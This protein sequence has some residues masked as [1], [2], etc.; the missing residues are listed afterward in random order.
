MDPVHDFALSPGE[1]VAAIGAGGTTRLLGRIA[2]DWAAA[3][4][5]PWIAA[6]TR[7]DDRELPESARVL[8]L[9]AEPAARLAAVREHPLRGRLGEA[10]AVG[11][12]PGATG[13]L[14]TLAEAEIAALAAEWG[15]DLVLVKADGTRGQPLKAHASHEPAIPA[16]AD[17]VIAVAGL[18]VLG[19]PLDEEHV[20]HAELAAELWGYAPGETVDESLVVRML[21]EPEG[22][23]RRVPPRARYAAFLHTR[24][25]ARLAAA[26]GRIAESLARAGVACSSGDLGEPAPRR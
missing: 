3:G 17:L 11:V 14:G 13:P 20:H 21:A 15:A 24:G 4:G 23:R 18:W 8:R 5:R 9:P 19:E 6:T 2:L 26:A 10:L 25:D 7:L 16:R 1:W 22:Y 12:S